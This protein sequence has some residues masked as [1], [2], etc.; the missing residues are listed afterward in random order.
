MGFQD[1]SVWMQNSSFSHCVMLTLHTLM[2][3]KEMSQF[4]PLMSVPIPA[5][6]SNENKRQEKQKALHFIRARARLPG[7]KFRFY[8]L[9]A[10]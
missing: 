10:V 5:A 4:R 6:L 1:R 9:L 8:H 3:Q 2:S 7:F